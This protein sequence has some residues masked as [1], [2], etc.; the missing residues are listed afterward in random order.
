MYIKKLENKVVSCFQAF[1]M[2]VNQVGIN[3]ISLYIYADL[4]E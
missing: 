1:F 3:V 2:P 4:N